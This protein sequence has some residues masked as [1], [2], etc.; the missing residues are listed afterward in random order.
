[1]K[2]IRNTRLWPVGY[3][4]GVGVLLNGVTASILCALNW[5][6]LGDDRRAR[7]AW[8]IAGVGAAAMVGVI[9]IPK[10]PA[11]AG[12]VLSILMTKQVIRGLEVPWRTHKAQSGPVAN[13][14]VPI[15]ATIGGLVVLVMLYVVTL[16]A[17][18]IEDVEG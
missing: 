2:E 15:L 16:M 3:I 8:I 1:M 13:R 12:L 14:L 4:W 17:L 18:G 9:T 5:K 6:R 7:E 11:F 10:V